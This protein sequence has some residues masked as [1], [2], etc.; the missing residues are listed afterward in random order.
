MFGWRADEVI[1]MQM[2][3]FRWIY[4]DDEPR[5]AEVLHELTSGTK[6]RCFSAN[7]NYRKDASL[8]HCEWY[9]SS[10]I[11]DAGNL[12]S[13][14]SLVLDVTERKR[15]E[16]DLRKSRDELELR[17]EERTADLQTYMAKLQESNQ[18]LQDFSFIA[19]HD[20]QEPLRKVKSF[21]S[22]LKQRCVDSLGEQEKDF[23]RRMLD[24]NER[25]DSLLKALREYSRLTT[26]AEPFVEVELT[27][28]I[29][30]VL[31]DLEVRIEKTGGKVLV[32]KLPAIKADPTQM[33]QLFQNLI[34]NALKFHKEGVKPVIEVRSTTIGNSKLQIVV[35]DNGIGFEEQYIE[36]IFTPFQRLHG[37]DSHYEG[38]GMGLAI[39]KKIVERHGGSIT[40]KSTPGLG[41]SFIIQFPMVTARRP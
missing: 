17:V 36:K 9:N 16:E 8:I 34:A 30:D 21:G 39:C 4:E 15:M 14:L 26:R 33:R 27:Q 19:A 10:L 24:A 2:K 29:H 3:D 23:L 40:A 37:R 5:V 12:R 28:I 6:P 31:S 11:D 32:E 1:G 25:M 7:R 13:I 41:T 38:T 18:A 22:M 20:L 35:E